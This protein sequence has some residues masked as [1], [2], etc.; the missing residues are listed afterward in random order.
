MPRLRGT[1]SGCLSH[2]RVFH[3][4]H[5]HATLLTIANARRRS[6]AVTELIAISETTVGG[7]LGSVTSDNWVKLLPV[8]S[9]VTLADHYHRLWASSAA[10]LTLSPSAS[11]GALDGPAG[12]TIVG[13]DRGSRRHE[14]LGYRLAT[15]QLPGEL[16]S[17]LVHRQRER[18]L[19]RP[20]GTHFG[21]PSRCRVE[22][23]PPLPSPGGVLKRSRRIMPLA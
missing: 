10:S 21:S 17:G 7:R 1:V 23:P 2:T 16:F 3:R 13:F 19:C 18:T 4:G 22:I 8:P 11:A 12:C 5:E 15:C 6:K 20:D 14:Q 9:T